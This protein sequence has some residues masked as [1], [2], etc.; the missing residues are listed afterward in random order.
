MGRGCTGGAQADLKKGQRGSLGTHKASSLARA[1]NN[2]ISWVRGFQCHTT[3]L[4]MAA[5]GM[6]MLHYY[7]DYI[8]LCLTESINLFTA[9][10]HFRAAI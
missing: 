7:R 1:V 9:N 8:S 5:R 10:H 4:E 3:S 2:D 6:L